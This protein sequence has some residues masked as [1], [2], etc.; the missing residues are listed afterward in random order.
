MSGELLTTKQ[1]KALKEHKYS[2]QGSSLCEPVMQIFWKWLVEQ[3]PRTW[4]PN[5][6]TL[7]GLL[8][9]VVSSAVLML[10]N[11]DGLHESPRW[12]YV[13]CASGLFIYQSLDAID[14]KQARRTQS[15][16]PLGEL[17]DHGCDSLS[18]V[19]VM[20]GCCISLK[21]GQEPMVLLF[22]ICASELCFY[23][24]HW[25]TY[26]TGTLKFGMI[27]VTEGQFTVIFIYTICAIS[28]GFFDNTLPV[29][30]VPLRYL[31]ALGSWLPSMYFIF[32]TSQ[33]I[34]QGGVGKNKSTVAGSSTIFPVLPI[35]L[36]LALQVIIAN[37]TSVY[38]DQPCLYLLSFGFV[39]SKITNSLV[40]AHMTKSEMHLLDWSL[41]GPMM[42]FM[43]Q[44]FNSKF[45]EYILLWIVF[46]YS[47][48]NWLTY[49]YN[50]CREICA[51]LNIY[52]FNITEKPNGERKTS[53][54]DK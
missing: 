18:T 33:L 15:N 51:H 24:A 8:M 31:C 9:N 50:V 47:L 37:K 3:I 35:G 19:F 17:F 27:D 2:A 12:V 7:I 10:Y 14:G 1:I 5:M 20:V 21:L 25:Q 45:N 46:I 28:P 13:M 32:K 16:T 34:L 53:D 49:N 43:N 26:V 22:E 36:L 41:L 52:C 4:S 30:G 39:Y 54:K 40:V 38:V 11:P 42:L 23:M 48:Q 6:I 44:Y 29:V